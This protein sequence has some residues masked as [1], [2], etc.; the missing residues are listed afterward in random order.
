VWTLRPNQTDDGRSEC[1]LTAL[2]YRSRGST[3]TAPC[4]P[5][6]VP[7]RPGPN[8]M[9]VAASTAPGVTVRVHAAAAVSSPRSCNHPEGVS[10]ERDELSLTHTHYLS[11]PL[12]SYL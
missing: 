1:A 7:C 5:A 3:C 9:E 10:R 4:S 8:T 11:L 2:E 12:V 6:R